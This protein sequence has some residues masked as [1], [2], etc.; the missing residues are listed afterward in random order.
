MFIILCIIVTFIHKFE[1]D[2]IAWTFFFK[3]SFQFHHCSGLEIRSR[4]P[5]LWWKWKP[6]GRLPPCTAF[7][8]KLAYI[9]FDNKPTLTC[10]PR[11]T[12]PPDRW[13]N[14]QNYIMTRFLKWVKTSRPK[15]TCN[16]KTLSTFMEKQKISHTWCIYSCQHPFFGLFTL[17]QNL[18]LT[19]A[20]AW[21]R[22]M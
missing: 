7:Q 16:D 20:I 22:E 18:V 21:R 3:H 6:Q 10:L 13:A 8:D 17:S 4:P 15:W 9:V 11:M 1:L 19:S 5:K 14:A 2:W 12:S